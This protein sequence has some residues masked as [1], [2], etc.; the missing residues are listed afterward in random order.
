MDI[1]KLRRSYE[2]ASLNRA[3]LNDCP[4]KQFQR[5]FG[6]AKELEAPN[7]FEP[8]AMTLA[9][10]DATGA[11]TARIVLLK[12]VSGA[13]FSFFTNYESLKA[14]QI[15]VNPQGSLLFYWANMERQVRIN[16]AIVKTDPD[17]SDQYFYE[18]PRGSQI[19]A[20]VSK[21]SQPLQQRQ[22]LDDEVAQLTDSLS[23]Q[24]VPRPDFW[25]GYT[26]QPSYFEF[27]QGRPNRLHDRFI[28]EQQPGGKWGITRLSP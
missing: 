10:A 11:A 15:G 19:A 12:S 5:W 24:K 7:W 27:W 8:N 28:Y 3:D 17:A 14:K 22:D 16:G 1:K 13:G 9:T 23:G 21:Q 6:E 20:A 25:G 4:Y 18:R 2:E 26:L